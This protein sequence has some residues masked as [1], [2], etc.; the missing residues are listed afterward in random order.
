MKT[1]YPLLFVLLFLFSCNNL[2]KDNANSDKELPEI[3]E[4]KEDPV[5]SVVNNNTTVNNEED[6]IGYWVGWFLP[7]EDID[8]DE[9]DDD[10][11]IFNEGINWTRENKITISIDTIQSDTVIG[12]SIVAGNFRPFHGS[13][14]FD[15]HAFKINVQEPGNDKYDGKFSFEIEKLNDTIQGKWIAYNKVQTPKRKYNLTKKSFNY[16]PLAEINEHFVD[17]VKTKTVKGQI[18]S[19]ELVDM[20]AYFTTTEKVTSL[21]SSAELLTDEQVSKLTKADIYVL[22][23]AIYAKHGYS[24]KKRALRVFFDRHDWYMP[25]HTNIKAELTNIEKQNIKL[26]LRYEKYAEEYYDE[27]GRG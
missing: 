1:I 7:D 2:I 15:G 16:D 24:F 22:R 20:E 13:I 19:D 4:L 26:L 11:N 9:W 18:D 27:F 21:N 12:H 25:V 23:N 17:W 14:K 8:K 3:S 6:L 5:H 10:R